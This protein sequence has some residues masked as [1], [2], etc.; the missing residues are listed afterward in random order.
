MKSFEE[1]KKGFS[2]DR[3]DYAYCFHDDY[4][5]EGMDYDGGGEYYTGITY[6]G[7]AYGARAAIGDDYNYDEDI[8]DNFGN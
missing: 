3:A 8:E 6:Y 2:D 5:E 1:F 4:T 7:K